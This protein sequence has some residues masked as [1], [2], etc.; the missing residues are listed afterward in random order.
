MWSVADVRPE[1]GVYAGKGEALWKSQFVTSGS[2]LVFPFQGRVLAASMGKEAVLY[3]LD[4]ASL[5]GGTPDHATPYLK[6]PQLGNDAAL[7]TEPGQGMWGALAT[8]QNPQG[9]R[10]VYMPM[11]GP[12][13]KNAPAF[14]SANGAIPH[15]SIMALQVVEK[16]GAF[17]LVPQWIS[18]DLQVP[19]NVAVAGGVVFAVQT[20]EQTAQHRTH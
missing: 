7:G 19:D 17:S 5:G 6:S 14:P 11:W 8:Y 18:R 3:L 2:L 20:G 1:L 13:S 16:D 10:F 9:R 15:G 12:P 4:T